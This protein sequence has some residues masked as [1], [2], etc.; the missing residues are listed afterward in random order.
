MVLIGITGPYVVVLYTPI[1]TALFMVVMRVD[2][3]SQWAGGDGQTYYV[4]HLRV[5]S[6][7][8]WAS[9]RNGII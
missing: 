9:Y 8:H 6:S 2:C 1:A 4:I 7:L 5:V 3:C